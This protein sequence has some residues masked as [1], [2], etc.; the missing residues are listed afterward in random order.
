MS[1][2]SKSDNNTN[3][4]IEKNHK[5]LMDFIENPTS[6]DDLDEFSLI[7]SRLNNTHE[8]H[9][10]KVR[11]IL[12]HKPVDF[13]VKSDGRIVGFGKYE[14]LDIGWAESL[15]SFIPNSANY[16][17]FN[18][19]PPI[20]QIPNQTKIAVFGDFGTGDW[21]GR[22]I[23]TTISNEIKNLQAD[24]VIHLGDIYYAA[25]SH[26]VEKKFL[27]FWPTAPQGNFT[28]IGNHEMYDGAHS[29]FNIALKNAIFKLQQQ[30][31]YFALENDH[32]VIACLDSAY[33]ADKTVVMDYGKIDENQIA[34]LKEINKKNKPIIVMTHHRPLELPGTKKTGLYQQI[35]DVIG[36]NIKYWYYGH[37]HC[38]AVYQEMDNIKFRLCGHAALPYGEPSVLKNNPN[39]I[40]YEKTKIPND[41]SMKVQNGFSCLHLKNDKIIEE[42][43]GED[44]KMHWSN[45]N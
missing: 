27:P 36:K 40:W 38:A 13:A 34:F 28:L 43:Y 1:V 30:N 20:I 19:N 25:S 3:D 32:W 8:P 11:H 41:N 33:F 17:K 31:S 9:M 21:N 22:N 39:V 2:Q 26:E 29:Y 45:E 23:A 5:A 10:E 44:G 35:V 14:I 42:F 6:V 37:V 7:K 15:L 18:T 24:Y 16:A 12:H 4:M